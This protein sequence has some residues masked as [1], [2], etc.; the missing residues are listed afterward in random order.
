MKSKKGARVPLADKL[1]HNTPRREQSSAADKMKHINADHPSDHCSPLSKPI[2]ARLKTGKGL[3]PS[4]AQRKAPQKVEVIDLDSDGVTG[5]WLP[6]CLC[7]E[8]LNF[9]ISD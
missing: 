3:A 4:P 7:A 1:A 2:S 8:M 5:Q 6:S 9:D